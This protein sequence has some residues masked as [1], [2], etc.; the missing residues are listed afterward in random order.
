MEGDDIR[1]VP[2]EPDTIYV[3]EYDPDDVYD[4]PEGVRGPVHHLRRRV[5]RGRLARLR[6]RLGRF[7]NL[8]RALASGLGLPE[9]LGRD[10][11]RGQPL[12]SRSGARPR[13]RAATTT[14]RAETFPALA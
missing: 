5:S 14:G 6:M 1:I 11:V 12:A 4:V 10:T 2:A 9:G 7:R 3:P 13:A 8:G